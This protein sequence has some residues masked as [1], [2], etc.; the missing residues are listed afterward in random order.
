M[1]CNEN[2]LG[3]EPDE[4]NSEGLTP[5]HIAL[6]VGNVNIVTYFFEA[7]PP[8]DPD[9]QAMYE[10]PEGQSL[11]A[12][13][14]QSH[15]SRT[16]DLVLSNGLASAEDIRLAW[17]WATS[18]AFGDV[19]SMKEL[20]NI[21]ALLRCYGGATSCPTSR[22]TCSDT[23]SAGGSDRSGSEG[24][25]RPH[26][27]QREPEIGGDSPDRAGKANR[28]ERGGYE[29]GGNRGRGGGGSRGRG[30]GLR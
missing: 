30:R 29:R 25:G 2:P 11:L 13:A 8:K 24:K 22:S 3:A 4:R 26:R 16:A 6:K 21:L 5:V 15:S 17:G 14:L 19:T 28:R 27:G 7:Y 12:F 1:P 23:E 9:H 20:D 18:D 10:A